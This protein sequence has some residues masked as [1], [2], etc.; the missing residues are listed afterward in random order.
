MTAAVPDMPD[1]P[2]RWRSMLFVPGNRPELAAKAPRSEPDVVVLDL[3]DAVPAPSKAEAR[4][5]VRTAA[6][7]LAGVVPVCVRVNPPTTSWFA[8][9][10]AALPPGLAGVVVPKLESAAQL[11][12]VADALGG[13]PIV[14][15]IETVRGVADAREVLAPPVA[16]CYFGA[17]DY[18]AD[19]G[20]VRT[21]GNAEVAYARSFVA[22]AARLAGV[23]ALDMVTID[24]RDDARFS[25][26]AREARSLGYAGK[27]CIHP[28]QVALAHEAFRPTA[29]EADWARRLLAAF[30]AAG[31][32]TIAFE[33]QM[34]DEVVAAR[35]RAILAA[36]EDTE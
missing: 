18:V 13:R 25:A 7:E 30:S 29:E 17:E 3:E 12:E 34:V 19:L 8:D 9:D 28:A 15:G 10:A 16:A 22:M 11:A 4:E 23:P 20:G 32:D 31:G 2:A 27:L 14:A 26:E 21:P 1:F 33:G 5:T 35:A 36:A 24:F 6:A